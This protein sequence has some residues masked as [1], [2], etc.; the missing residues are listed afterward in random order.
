M[1]RGGE[2]ERGKIIGRCVAAFPYMW[3]IV[4]ATPC[5]SYLLLADDCSV[6]PCQ[7]VSADLI[8]LVCSLLTSLLLGLCLPGCECFP[9]FILFVV[10][11]LLYCSVSVYQEVG[12]TFCLSC[13]LPADL[14]HC[15]CSPACECW[16]LSHLLSA[17]LSLLTS[18]WVL[19]LIILIHCL[20]TSVSLCLCL[21]GGECPSSYYS[22]LADLS[23]SAYQEVRVLV[24]YHIC[25]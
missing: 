24:V 2:K 5:L 12:A 7:N 10:C 22:L 19:P 6:T 25:C 14:S 8:C 11:W 1:F 16:A 21:P 13:S 9:L 3:F 23:V 17:D 15:L 20:L 18:L 4:S